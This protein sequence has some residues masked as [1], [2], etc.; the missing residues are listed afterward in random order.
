MPAPLRY[1]TRD[2]PGPVW[3]RN[4]LTLKAGSGSLDSS[5][6]LCIT[7]VIVQVHEIPN[8]HERL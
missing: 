2:L 3:F 5:A 7:W 8:I 6:W 4:A 1:A